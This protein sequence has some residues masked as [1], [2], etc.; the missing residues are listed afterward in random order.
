MTNEN[1]CIMSSRCKYAG[2]PSHC[3]ELCFP[4]RKA[5]GESGESGLVGLADV[6]KKYRNCKLDNLPIEQENP[7]AYVAIKHISQN[8][9]A[10]I[11]HGVGLYLYSVPNAENPRGTGT[12]KTTSAIT[13]LNEYLAYRIVQHIKHEKSITTHIPALFV[14]ASKF[15]NVYNAQF[16]GTSEMKDQ[17]S[18]EFYTLKKHMLTTDLLVID[19]IGLRNSTEAMTN[20]LYEIIDERASEEKAFILTSNVPIEDLNEILSHQIGSRIEGACEQIA[21][22]GKDFRRGN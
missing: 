9:E 13:I 17:A 11:D 8:I 15:Q 12:G 5:H 1:K 22:Q 4:F 21:F 6:P 3:H 10:F 14:R 20:E 7:V 16:R 2:K 19:D 18:Q